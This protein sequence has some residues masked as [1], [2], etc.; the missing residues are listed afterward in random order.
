M[1]ENNDAYRLKI[2]IENYVL[3]FDKK[4]LKKVIRQA[5]RETVAIAK[6]LIR[7]TQ[8]VR[9][10][11]GR[12]VSLPGEAPA[13]QTGALLADFKVKTS[14]NGGSVLVADN[15]HY[16][17]YQEKGAV[18]GGGRKG[19]R[20][21]ISRKGRKRTILEVSTRRVLEPRPYLFPALEQETVGLSERIEKAVL[22]GINLKET[23]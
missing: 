18:G 13:V 14:R 12:T 20:N 10:K 9:K 11:D 17:L 22:L 6:K 2:G 7:N 3:N 16:A 5:G 23:K 4:Q 8:K 15:A 1:A 19:N 21:K